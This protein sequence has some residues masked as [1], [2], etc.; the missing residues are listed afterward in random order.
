MPPPPQYSQD[1]KAAILAKARELQR[2]GCTKLAISR[3][4][5]VNV[6]SLSAWLRD[7]TLDQLYP[8]KPHLMPRNRSETRFGYDGKGSLAES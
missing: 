3:Q 7:Q 1:E 4:L 2:A 5:G 6:A 8:P